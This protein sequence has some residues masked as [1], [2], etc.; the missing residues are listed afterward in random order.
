MKEKIRMNSLVQV[1]CKNVMVSD[2]VAAIFGEAHYDLFAVRSNRLCGIYSP[3]ESRSTR[4][5][6]KRTLN[7][8]EPS[9][10]W[11]QNILLKLRN[12]THVSRS[13]TEVILILLNIIR[14]KDIFCKTSCREF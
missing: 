11:F 12:D 9:T 6:S 5:W 8:R 13:I 2:V 10:L 14:R 7:V 1:V 4:K 3:D